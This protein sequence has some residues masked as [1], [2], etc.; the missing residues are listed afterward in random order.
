M[1]LRLERSESIPAL[2]ESMTERVLGE[3]GTSVGPSGH[4]S[5]LWLKDGRQ[6]DIFLQK[7]A[8]NGCPGW[9][10]PP[11]TLWNNLPSRFDL[12]DR[13]IGVLTQQTIFVTSLISSTRNRAGGRQ[14][15]LE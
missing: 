1:P 3:L 9:L 11:F 2:W 4:T 12:R 10:G 6:R 7:A 8:Q 5:H 14:H 15:L 13:K